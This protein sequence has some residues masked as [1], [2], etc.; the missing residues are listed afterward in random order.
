MCYIQLQRPP[1]LILYLLLFIHNQKVVICVKMRV[2]ALSAKRCQLF[3][4]CQRDDRKYWIIENE[5]KCA[6]FD[7]CLIHVHKL[8]TSACSSCKHIMLI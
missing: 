7:S 5:H 8:K 1:V 6:V 3:L 4:F 2:K